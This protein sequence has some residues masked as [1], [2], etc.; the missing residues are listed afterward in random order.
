MTSVAESLAITVVGQCASDGLFA[1]PC[2]SLSQLTASREH[3]GN[4]A[5][6]AADLQNAIAKAIAETTALMAA[7]DTDAADILGFQLALLE[8]DALVAPCWHAIA[9][10]AS[11]HGAWAA[12]LDAH[13][14]DYQASDDAYFQARSADLEDLRDHV[15]RLM[16]GEVAQQLPTGHV[17]VGEEIS[18]SQFLGHDWSEGGAIVLARGSSTSHVAM[19]ARAR[20]IAMVVQVDRLPLNFNGRVQVDA[21][22]AQVIFDPDA[23]QRHGFALRLE[24]ATNR[25]AIESQFLFAPAQCADG[26]GIKLLINIAGPDDIANLDPAMCDGVG[27]MR[28]EFLFRDGAPLPDE[29]TQF[30]AYRRVLQWA[31]DKPVTIRTLDIG[32]DKPIRGLTPE[33]ES[34][35]F[36]G[37]RG[38]RLTLARPDVFQ[39]QLRALARAAVF[40]NLSVMLPMVTIAEEISASAA[41]LAEVVAALNAEGVACKAPPLG[42]MVEVPAAAIAPELFTAAAFFSIGS[43]DLA[44]YVTA[45]SRDGG[46][47]SSLHDVPHPAVLKLIHN[48]V[49]FASQHSM[50]ISICGDMASD[51]NHIPALLGCGLRSLS[52]AVSRVA[53]IK[54]AL[55]KA[56]CGN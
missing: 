23:Q 7:S 38:V 20:G 1:G 50:P 5:A 49:S 39:V 54:H 19:L 43:N 40:G 36:L 48:L 11:A 30:Q 44:Q 3:T 8:D 17:L 10:H 45:A 55:S 22:A 34:N 21:E 37:L 52:V 28:S 47:V 9:N 12:T 15:L 24:E 41:L 26:T 29:E 13:I 35:P 56:R 42:I 27:L 2:H 18:P 53:R 25:K 33:A 6:E 16:T 4:P 46:A 51:E 14:R 31:G 32:G